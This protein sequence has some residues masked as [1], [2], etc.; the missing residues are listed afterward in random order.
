[1]RPATTWVFP[2][3]HHSICAN[4]GPINGNAETLGWPNGFAPGFWPVV[5]GG[6]DDP[7]FEPCTNFEPMADATSC[8]KHYRCQ[9]EADHLALLPLVDKLL[10]CPHSHIG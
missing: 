7:R 2:Q 3:T 1:M 10:C 4:I 9:W 5:L 6:L 8:G